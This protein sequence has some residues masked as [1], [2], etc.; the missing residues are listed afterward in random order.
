MSSTLIA[1]QSRDTAVSLRLSSRSFLRRSLTTLL[2]LL[3]GVKTKE[4]S[5]LKMRK[6]SFQYP[7][8][9][10]QQL[11]DINLQERIALMEQEKTKEKCP[12]ISSINRCRIIV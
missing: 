10:V 3:E 6:V 7:M 2:R 1:S 5:L 11:Y 9:P 4:K 12:R 8:Q